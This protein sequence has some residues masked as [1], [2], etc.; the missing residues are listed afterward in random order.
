MLAHNHEP[1]CDV[2]NKKFMSKLLEKYRKLICLAASIALILIFT[3]V[4]A[5][6]PISLRVESYVA[7]FLVDAIFFLGYV[8]A[9]AK[10]FNHKQLI[11]V[12]RFSGFGIFIA[13][14]FHAIILIPNLIVASND[15]PVFVG[16]NWTWLIA[17]SLGP[18]LLEEAFLR[19]YLSDLLRH[20]KVAFLVVIFVQGALFA[21]FH[22][23]PNNLPRVMF[24]FVFGVLLTVGRLNFNSLAW[25]IGV[26]FSWNLLTGIIY[27]VPN[28]AARSTG[29][30]HPSSFGAPHYYLL[31]IC[32]L[33][34]SI[35]FIHQFRKQK[36]I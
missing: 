28:V 5:H 32:F 35:F 10:N 15:V 36:Y 33:A 34:T 6:K 23:T 7:I 8:T 19:G 13:C 16:I 22:F 18:A 25:P 21:A 2:A 4:T 26:H 3:A 17:F 12:L 11:H 31:I 27:G 20:F 29:F 24:F 30:V 14:I 9:D 1:A